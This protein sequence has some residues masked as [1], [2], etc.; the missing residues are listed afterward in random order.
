MPESNI[1]KSSFNKTKTN[2]NLT[3]NVKF[4]L[5]T[6]STSSKFILINP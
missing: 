3:V 6:A 1:V 4:N 5:A 2:K